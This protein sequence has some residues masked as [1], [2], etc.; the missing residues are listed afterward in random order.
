VKIELRNRKKC[1]KKV[2]KRSDQK[3]NEESRQDVGDLHRVQT[4][5]EGHER[6]FVFMSFT[7][8]AVR[9]GRT[10]S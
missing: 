6:S 7:G 5:S 3:Q 9:E 2:T 4:A 1:V 10:T 8:M